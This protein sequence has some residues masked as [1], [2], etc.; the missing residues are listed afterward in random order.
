M[1]A[2]VHCVLRLLMCFSASFFNITDNIYNC[3]FNDRGP[4]GVLNLEAVLGGVL[5]SFAII[6]NHGDDCV[7]APVFA[8]LPHFLRAD[9]YYM[10]VLRY[11]LFIANVR[12]DGAWI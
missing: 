1:R 11:S 10:F 8:S 2:R 3:A 6:M 12:G 7:A 4:E 9:P 5:P